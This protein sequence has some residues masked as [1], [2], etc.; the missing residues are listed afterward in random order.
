MKSRYDA[1]IIGGGPGGAIAAGDLALAGHSVCLVEKRP[2]IGAP[3]RCAEGIGKDILAEFIEPDDRWISA[4]IKGARIVAPD[5]VSMTLEQQMAGSKVGYIL[6]R[7]VFD[8]ELVWQAAS[9]GAEVHVK[10]RATGAIVE[11]GAVK[12]AIIETCGRAREVRADVVIA[13]DGVESKFARWCG[14]DSAVPMRELM[15]CAQYILTDIDIEPAVTV[16]YL[17]NKVAPEGY[18]WVF[19]KGER[20]ANVGIGISSRR[21]RDGNRARDYLDR[22]VAAHFPKGKTIEYI[23]G[24]VPVCRPL[25]CTVADG[26]MVVGDAARVADPMTG[27]GIYNAMQTGRLAAGVASKGISAGDCSRSAL[28]AYDQAWR[29]SKLGKTLERNW[30]IKEYFITLSDEKLNAI[31]HSISKMNLKD[32]SVFNLVKELIRHNPRLLLELKGLHDSLTAD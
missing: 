27:G 8:R 30:K 26:L 2:A 3:V 29:H 15:S 1:L 17:G 31:V 4:E 11:S 18:A 5:G 7:K 6:D 12:G 21:S 19:P 9:K 24:G 14:I 28:M 23:V 25:P 13:A 20:T 32:F 10:T 22:F 16:F